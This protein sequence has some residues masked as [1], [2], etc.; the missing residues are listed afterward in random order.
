MFNSTANMYGDI[1]ACI[2]IS[3]T[4]AE[5][6][7]LKHIRE[8]HILEPYWDFSRLLQVQGRAIRKDSHSDLPETDRNVKTY[9][10][11]STPNKKA[12]DISKFRE[13]ETIDQRFLRNAVRKY[14]LIEK[15]LMAMKEVSI[16]CVS[17]QYNKFDVDCRICTPDDAQLF[18][19]KDV[20]GDINKPDPCRE[21]S[22]E[23][24]K[25]KLI[26]IEGKKFNYREDHTSPLGYIIYQYND[27]LNGYMELPLNSKE[28]LQI[29]DAIE[30]K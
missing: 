12:R 3:E 8:V 7:D 24:I 19:P 25:T 13:N 26:T 30:A 9:V 22:K 16:E 14:K 29:V 2:L 4:G 11:V 28:A 20:S 6:L 17:N 21:F 15:F 5:G 23:T 18:H 1:I 27:E 10:Y